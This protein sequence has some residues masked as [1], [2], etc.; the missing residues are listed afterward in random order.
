M[1][2][3]EDIVADVVMPLLMAQFA[4][5]GRVTRTP[6]GTAGTS[7]EAI[8]GEE[9]IDRRGSDSGLVLEFVRQVTV[10]A[11]VEAKMNDAWTV[12]DVAYAVRRITPT[13]DGYLTV[14]LVR[15]SAAELSRSDLRRTR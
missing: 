15:R 2:V 8:V 12:D 14:E 10:E 5:S 1:S 9:T 6:Q 13:G 7:V 4:D 11:S 3:H